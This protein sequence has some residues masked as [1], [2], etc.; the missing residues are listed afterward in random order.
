MTTLDQ[1]RDLLQSIP[2]ACVTIYEQSRI[3]LSNRYAEHL[4]GYTAEELAGRLINTL[5]PKLFRDGHIQDGDK[6]YLNNRNSR[7]IDEPVELI[8]FHRNGSMIPVEIGLSSVEMNGDHFILAIIH[9][10]TRHKQTEER[11]RRL[12]EQFS[13]QSARLISLSEGGNPVSSSITI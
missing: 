12:Q 9:D 5:L 3:V 4:F 6:Y 1:F 8:A 13:Q 7:S 11:L 10:I 2:Y